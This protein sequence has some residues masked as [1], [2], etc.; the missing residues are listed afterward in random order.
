MISNSKKSEI[1]KARIQAVYAKRKGNGRYSWFSP[2]HLFMIQERERALL[3]LLRA[4]SITSL[5][6][7]RI[8][9]VGCGTGYWL[10]QFINW[11]ARPQ[12]ITGVDLL[13]DRVIEAKKICPEIMKIECG[14]AAELRVDDSY[15]DLVLQSMVF[16]SI[17]NQ[18][19]KQQIASEMLRVVKVD[20]VILWYDFHVNNPANH[21][22]GGIKKQEIFR[23]FPECEIELCRITLAAPLVRFLAPHSWLL[24]YLL[25]QFKIFNTHYLGIIRKT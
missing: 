10:R 15:Y 24:C 23:L 25:G 12:N 2:G 16:S 11:G 14:S 3:N 17:L 19:M 18:E 21:D 9:D 6:E 22:V 8:L 7:K 1:E 13:S 4:K 20:G 5:E